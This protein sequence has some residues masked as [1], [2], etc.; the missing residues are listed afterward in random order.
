M[1]IAKVARI[2]AYF[3]CTFDCYFYYFGP[4]LLKTSANLFMIA[5]ATLAGTKQNPILAKRC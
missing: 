2:L 3:Y 1:T 5:M 4:A